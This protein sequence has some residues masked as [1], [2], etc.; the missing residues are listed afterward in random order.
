MAWVKFVRE[1][2]EIEVNAG[3]SVLEA[4]IRA[5]LRPD[6]PCGGLG[7]CGKCLVKINGEVV[8]ACQVRIG[9]GETC[10]VETLDRAGNEKILTDGFNREVVFEPGL[11]M[12]QVELEKAKTGEKRSDW[13]RLLDTLAETDGEVEPGLIGNPISPCIYFTSYSCNS[14]CNY[15][16]YP[17]TFISRTILRS[18]NTIDGATDSSSSPMRTNSSVR[19]VSAPSS[20]Q[21]PAHFPHL[22]ALSTTIWIIRSS[23]SWCGL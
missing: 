15:N 20:P 7:K 17:S 11:R 14:F 13:Q 19:V 5:G 23:A 10:V 1:G 3:M 6:A 18:F 8:K 4:E 21:M 9:E 12:A 22:C 2:I 16:N